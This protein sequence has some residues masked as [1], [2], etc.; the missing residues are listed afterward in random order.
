MPR[1]PVVN[2]RNLSPFVQKFIS[3]TEEG[4]AAATQLAALL[5]VS[6]GSVV[7]TALR[8]LAGTAPEEI[9][10]QLRE[11]GHLTPEEY[12]YVRGR[13]AAKA[14]KP[15]RVKAATSTPTTATKLTSPKPKARRPR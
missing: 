10:E 13:L 1:H 15:T 3:V 12:D 14:P 4:Y 8:Q 7:D 6:T 2:R 9:L 11:A 5:E